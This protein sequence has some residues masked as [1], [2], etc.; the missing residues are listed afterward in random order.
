MAK[1]YKQTGNVLEI[2]EEVTET[3]VQHFRRGELEVEK[4]KLLERVA[5]IDEVLT[6]F[7]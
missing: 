4:E 3:K 1:Q 7:T 6:K 2:S 5:Q